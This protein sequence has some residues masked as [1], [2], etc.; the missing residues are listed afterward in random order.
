MNFEQN[1]NGKIESLKGIYKNP[2]KRA[3]LFFSFYFLFFFVLVLL[4]RNNQ[5]SN[6][7]QTT[8]IESSNK[9]QTSYNLKKLEEGNYQFTRKETRGDII[10]T[11]VGKHYQDKSSVTM[12]K[13]N[14]IK[15]FFFYGDIVLEENSNQYIV[16]VNPYL[17][18]TLQEYNTIDEILERSTLKAKTTY[19]QGG[20]CYQY[21]IT[22]T[23][24]T[25]ILDK[26]EIDISD[27]VNTIEVYVDKKEITGITYYLNSYHNYKTNENVPVTIEI[28]YSDYGKVE[29]LE[30]P[31]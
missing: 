26:Q 1:K 21:E 19:E 29:K 20:D 27:P 12:T 22:T 2:R 23:T 25:S 5:T 7:K 14:E 11:F 10:T 24:L 16:G 9:I 13:G 8:N 30:V 4:L 17:Y 15:N 3:I 31:E 18:P 6:N 28:K